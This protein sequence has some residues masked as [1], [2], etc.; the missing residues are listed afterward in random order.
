MLRAPAFAVLKKRRSEI[1]R[2]VRRK[3]NAIRAERYEGC[4]AGDAVLIAPV[5]TQIPC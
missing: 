4:V 2:I 3:Q 5:S 1:E